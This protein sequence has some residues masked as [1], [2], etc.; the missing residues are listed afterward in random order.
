MTDIKRNAAIFMA[1]DGYD[2]VKNGING[3]RV[4]G[5][6]F[7]RGFLRHGAVDEFVSLSSGAGGQQLF[8][9]VAADVGAKP[10]LR[11]VY[12]ANPMRI[13]PVG[14]LYYPSPNFA[15]ET[16]RRA[17]FDSASYS[18]CGITHTTATRAVMEGVHNLRTSPQMEWDGIICTSTSV[19]G[20]MVRLMDGVDDHLVQRFGAVPP[21]PQMP[22]IPLGIDCAEYARDD[23][24][25]ASYRAERGWGENDI[26]ISTL[27]RLSPE[28]K[29]D[30]LPLFIAL[31]QAQ[32]RLIGK[33]LHLLVCGVYNDQHSRKV[34]A[35]GARELM[36][37]VSYAELDGADILA[38]KRAYSAADI[39]SFPIDNVQET[40]GLAP[41]EAMAAGLPL[42][43]SD[44]DG[45][46]DTVTP[47]V[48]I[49][50]STKTLRGV[51][52]FYD[53]RRYLGKVYSYAQYTAILSALTQIDM[54][55]MVEAFVTLARDADLRAK[56][57]AAARERA[58]N[59]YDWSV[60]IP[61]MQEFWGELAAIRGAKARPLAR[62]T[63]PKVPIA[64]LPFDVFADY[65]TTQMVED[66]AVYLPTGIHG[67]RD[68]AMMHALRRYD[69]VGHAFEPG[70]RV[71][72]V[73]AAVGEGATQSEVVATTGLP[74]LTVDRCLIW[75]LKYDFVRIS[76]G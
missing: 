67:D 53:A 15:D 9:D 60:V 73:L 19:K 35:N 56:M 7:L 65:P 29:F 11:A 24:V 52:G 5:A 36:P 68:A 4:A 31:E 70:A 46:K 10:P 55:Q 28:G 61:Q 17:A 22:V 38:R 47:E 33:R 32:G 42:V 20:M 39:F 8:A 44:W 41:I 50:I 37:N 71:Q 16:W 58:R 1:S 6:S 45:M 26:V 34:F 13:A 75:L 3:R 66:A 21:R 49:R 27:S 12:L 76:T 54:P 69:A 74:D 48:G 62:G 43:V 51:H 40:F 63:M 57:G 25:R 30:P 18:I 23:A 64:P 59:V 14:T 2:P 72:M